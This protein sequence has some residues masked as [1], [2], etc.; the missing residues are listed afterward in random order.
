MEHCENHVPTRIRQVCALRSRNIRAGHSFGD[1]HSER[2][3]GHAG[4]RDTVRTRDAWNPDGAGNTVAPGDTDWPEPA[5]TDRH[6]AAC[7]RGHGID[8][9]QICVA[10]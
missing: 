8:L 9:W 3:N 1:D 2:W 6:D 4:P 10:I 5:R 7:Q